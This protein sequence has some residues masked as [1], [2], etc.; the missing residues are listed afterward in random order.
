MS[1]ITKIFGTHSEHEIKHINPIVDQVMAL[2]ETYASMSDEELQGMTAKLKERIGVGETLDSVLPDAFAVVR[3]AAF[4]V[5]GM[6]PYRVQVIGG[7]V[8]HQGRIAEMKTG[9]GK[10]LVATMP[11]YLNALTGKGV[12]IVT[13]N[14]YLAKRDSEWMGKVYKFLG[15][16]VGI[17]IHDVPTNKRR[18][19]YN[20][21]IVYGTNNEFGF[22]YLRDNMVVRQSQLC[23]RELNY[24]IVDEVDSILI[25]EARTPLIISGRG[26]ESSDM[27]GKADAFVRTLKPY[28]VIETDDT[29]NM[30]EI[31]GDCDYVI[32]EKATSTVLTANGVAKA[33]KY[34]DVE[35]LS[36]PDNFNLQHYINNAL[37]ANGIFKKDQ[38]YV[39]MDGE[40]I[41]VDDFTGRLMPGRRYSDGLHQAIEAKEGVKVANENKTLATV[42]FQNFFRMY[43]KLSGMTGTAY[44][45][46]GEFRSIY[47][48]DVIQIPTNKP[49]AR[50]DHQDAVF[51]TQKGKFTNLIKMVIDAHA[52]GQPVL[53][54]TVNVDKSEF[55]SKLFTKAG[56]KHNVLNA[57]NHMREAEIVAQAGR[58][59]AVTIATNMAGR[60][61]DI[62]LGGNA[63]YLAKQEMRK[64]GYTDEL[65]DAANAH[66]DT[67]DEL[68][69][70]ARERFSKLVS[71]FEVQIKP[72]A[73]EVRAAGGLLIIG[74]ERH[75][76]RR[77]DNQLCGRAGRQGDPGESKFFLALDDDLLRIFGGDRITNMFN[78][79]NVDENMEL[80]A[81]M[82][83][84]L[85]ESSQKKLEGIHFSS[86]KSVLEFDDV[87]NT[88]RTITYEQ[89]R[90][91]IDGA[92]MHETF[93]KM[94]SRVA[95]RTVD[96]FSLDGV[97]AK[98][99]SYPCGMKVADIFGNLPV[100]AE[101]LSENAPESVDADEIVAK[102]NEQSLV[103]LKEKEEMITTEIFREAERVILLS[104]VDQK[105]MD[106]I[107]AMDQLSQSIRMRSIAQHDPVVE[108]RMEGS[109][110]FDEMNDSI[111]NDSI[112]LLMKGRFSA[113]KRMET[114]SNVA[115]MSEGTGKEINKVPE[116]AGAAQAQVLNNKTTA[117]PV[118]RD[119]A[120]VGRNDNCPCGSGKKY[121]NCCGKNEK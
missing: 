76:S 23:Q 22:D 5:L 119:S 40:V 6:K 109:D 8:L 20:C 99:E 16:T 88:Q 100:V 95:E 59:G 35:N 106:H 94:L 9:E 54:G 37:K 72:E 32:D 105:W 63:E 83:T 34:F 12:H 57:K 77:I 39:V 65:I 98:K 84:S 108:Y 53:I 70:E 74:T 42:T 29:V 44:T 50:I 41:I 85:I 118:K 89:R 91:V 18:D 121:K 66:N 82:L 36:D 113:E 107:D 93:L 117:Q 21:D 116:Q 51:K 46:E 2:E 61:T 68:I 56:I 24:A 14:D 75:E 26:T 96:Q 27:Y 25:D 115:S 97:L 111:Q 60:G 49:I 86:R 30:D 17:I 15:L 28:T 33:E 7:I 87:M 102:I 92:D 1:I 4:R 79:L 80:Q 90:K 101:L 47:N 78:N 19:M 120:K 13:V 104:T 52:K 55:L 64:L 114:K 73:E 48:L 11:V 81:G 71:D 67:E 31:V 103:T 38:K 69:I 112:K 58:K 10:T 3:E 43:S 45:E 62:I 110:M